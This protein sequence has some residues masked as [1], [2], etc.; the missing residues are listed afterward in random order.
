MREQSSVCL[1][2]AR[3]PQR[4]D[5]ARVKMFGNQNEEGGVGEVKEGVEIEEYVCYQ[6]EMIKF[7]FYWGL[8]IGC[9]SSKNWRHFSFCR[10]ENWILIIKQFF[11]IA[12][13]MTQSHRPT[14]DE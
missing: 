3:R 6:I 1:A 12:L 4:I 13:C 2:Q 5:E 14:K 10:R 8:T 11:I 9:W 7:D